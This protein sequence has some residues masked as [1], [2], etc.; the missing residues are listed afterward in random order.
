MEES[1]NNNVREKKFNS[2]F[3]STFVSIFHIRFFSIFLL[4]FNSVQLFK[5]KYEQVEDHF[6]I[7]EQQLSLLRFSHTMLFTMMMI[8]DED[9][10]D[11]DDDICIM[12][13]CPSVCMS[14]C[15]VFNYFAFPT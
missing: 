3:W 9:G 1:G 15:H 8:D 11:D 12:V 4:I 13:K 6:N 2:N 10:D 14:V 5:N 7:I